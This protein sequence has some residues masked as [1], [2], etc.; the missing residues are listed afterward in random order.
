MIEVSPTLS[1]MLPGEWPA[2]SNS[3]SRCRCSM[4]PAIHTK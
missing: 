1:Q 4:C 3:R 2:G